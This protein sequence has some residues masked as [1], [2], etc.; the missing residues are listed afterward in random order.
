MKDAIQN[1]SGADYID[2]AC[3][4]YENAKRHITTSNLLSAQGLY[5]IAI[6]HIILG[7]EEYI[8]ALI[9]LNLSGDSEFINDSEKVELFKNHKFK[10]NNIKEFLKS[11]SD[12]AVEKYD[13]EMFDRL[14]NY[15]DPDS[16][17]SM[18]GFYISRVFDITS[19][20]ENDAAKLIKWL[21]KANDLKNNGF[22]INL[23]ENWESPERF[24]ADDYKEAN[25][26]IT[27]LQNAID[28]I[29]TLPMTDENLINYLNSRDI[30]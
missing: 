26:L 19:L 18:D 24:N 23:D 15:T 5:G 28:P 13:A 9:L 30:I 16:K 14:I 8:K 22:Y 3:L 20:T 11:L 17:Y 6:S 25:A 2:G 29:F 10:H 7:A 27:V 4:T 21:V 12:T 1:F